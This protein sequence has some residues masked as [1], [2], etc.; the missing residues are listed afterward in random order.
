MVVNVASPPSARSGSTGHRDPI[1][2]CGLL[3]F[4]TQGVRVVDVRARQVLEVV[5]AQ[6]ARPSWPMASS[7]GHTAQ[8]GASIVIARVKY[9]DGGAVSPG[10]TIACSS[11]VE[12]QF[13]N[14][15]WSTTRNSAQ[16]APKKSAALGLG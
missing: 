13:I 9:V 3:P 8:T 16:S 4:R 15:G 6:E 12:P 7:H 1:T 5:I 10:S 2:K 11:V 14:H